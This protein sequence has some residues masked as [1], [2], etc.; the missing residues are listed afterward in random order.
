MNVLVLGS[1]GREH[2]LAWSIA[3]SPALSRLFVAPGN[4]GTGRIAQNVPLDPA[5]VKQVATFV[6]REGI[7]LVVVGPEGPLVA[8]V[9]DAVRAEGCACF[10]P[11][12]EGARLEGSKAHAKSMM[13]SEG[14]P[15]ARAAVVRSV[16]EA[17]KAL[18]WLG[19]R[20]AVK[21]DGLAAG[22]G[23]VMAEDRAAAIEA[24]RAAVETRA[25]GDAG[26]SV[27]LEEWLEGEEASLM[28]LVDGEEVRPL[29]PSQD[30]KRAFDGDTGPNTGGMGA[31]APFGRLTGAT[32]EKAVDGCVRPIAQALAR[33]GVGFR[34][35]LYAG[36][37]IGPEG[38][39]VLEYNVR[40]GDPETEAVLPLLEDDALEVLAATAR[41]ELGSSPTLKTSRGAALTVV[42]ASRGYPAAPEKG[43]IIEG[44]EPPDDRGDAI[45]FHAG[46]ALSGK[47][48][49]TAGGRVLSV[50]GRGATLAEAREAAYRTLG[51]VRF[52]GMFFRRDIGARASSFQEA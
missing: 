13:E 33:H 8:G 39:K 26:A 7:D 31:Y 40:F 9:A 38:P 43:R 21:A 16:T 50:T 27:V 4:A 10:G 5:D 19:D 28:A 47:G 24:V 20:V 18:A 34:G 15:T 14:I 48:V 29:V 44:L 12:A 41:G 51:T 23:V 3:K 22:K 36:L 25:F 52:D 11:G 37:M 6:R 49:V 2:A 17:A 32:L 30:H 45:I 42:A 35:V 1:G 46:T